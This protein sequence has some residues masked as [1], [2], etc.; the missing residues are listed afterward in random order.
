MCSAGRLE[1]ERAP[2]RGHRNV[3]QD[4]PHLLWWPRTG[5]NRRGVV[6]RLVACAV[7]MLNASMVWAEYEI[8]V[9]LRRDRPSVEVG[10]ASLLV[11]DAE[12]GTPLVRLDGDGE[13]SL[14]ATQDGLALRRAGDPE[15]NARRV[16]VQGARAVRV[17]NGVYFGRIEIGSDPANSERL[18]V[19]NRLPL[20]T[21]LL[22]VVGSE[23]AASW[24]QEALKA[25]AVAARTYA[26][27]RRADNRARRRPYDL[28][29][30]ILSQV[31]RGAERIGPRVIE[32]VRAT[33]GEVL[34]YE[35]GLVDAVF[36]ST[37]GGT[38]KSSKSAFGGDLPYL[39]ARPCA[40]CR[41]SPT[42]R[43][44]KEFARNEASERLREAG[45]IGGEL[46]GLSRSEKDP[47]VRAEAKT[48]RA[49]AP[50][51]VRQALGSTDVPSDRFVV[52]TD[53][54]RVIVKGRGFG[55]GVGMCQWGARGQALA[56]RS[57]REIL[58]HYYPNARIFRLY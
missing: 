48:T 15:Q 55:H 8:R 50:K 40:W 57:Y 17:D 27:R 25:Q 12:A 14:V 51:A 53:E 45:L 43:W 30:T 42:Y 39:V 54:E 2:F 58:A 44:I 41:G 26:M 28:S 7:V 10:G 6:L 29:A 32:A 34:G 52:R 36:H 47:T 16:L 11:T 24:P 35:H 20:R 23:M 56:G 46:R 18:F 9:A 1:R 49:L 21:Y 4:G 37:C 31:Y 5:G 22:G 13:V 38:T 19:V 33:W 3:G